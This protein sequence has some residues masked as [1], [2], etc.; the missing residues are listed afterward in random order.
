MIQLPTWRGNAAKKVEAEAAAKNEA[1]AKILGPADGPTSF[2][3]R[4]QRGPGDLI[5]RDPDFQDADQVEDQVGDLYDDALK[6]AK[7]KE[8]HD[9]QYSAQLSSLEEKIAKAQAKTA[10]QDQERSSQDVYVP[11]VTQNW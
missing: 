3:Q 2:V 5:P 1:A 11:D 10:K 6:P 4:T 8:E 9:R 7:K